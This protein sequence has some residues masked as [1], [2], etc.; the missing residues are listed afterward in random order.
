[1]SA[2]SSLTGKGLSSTMQQ[3]ISDA[4]DNENGDISGQELAQ[5]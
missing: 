1:M 3:Y 2:I 5:G 4:A